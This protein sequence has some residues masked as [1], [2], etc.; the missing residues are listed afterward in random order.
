MKKHKGGRTADLH[1][2]ITP[3]MK[4]RLQM[5]VAKQGVSIADWIERYI[6][7]DEYTTTINSQK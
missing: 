4:D 6:K 5:L 1:T 2:R 3:E 7:L